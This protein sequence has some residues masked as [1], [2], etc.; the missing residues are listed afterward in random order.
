MITMSWLQAYGQDFP[1]HRAR[2]FLKR[3]QLGSRSQ[4][5]EEA[6]Q[7]YAQEI[8]WLCLRLEVPDEE[9]LRVFVQ[10]LIPPLKEHVLC[11]QP[12]DIDQSLTMA[13]AKE[14][15]IQASRRYDTTPTV[16]AISAK[17]PQNATNLLQQM[18]Q[19][20]DSKL[21]NFMTQN[22]QYQQRR[23]GPTAPVICY[24]CNYPGHIQRHCRLRQQQYP[25]PSGSS[26]YQPSP[27]QH[28]WTS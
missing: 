8:A 19:M 15:S 4:R 17:P 24:Y 5:A 1:Y 2:D 18:E 6:V 11:R 20:I 12:D 23:D 25:A 7:N 16:A 28:I 13:M 9:H 3:Q 21:A 26:F 10:G 22:P 27:R 14:C